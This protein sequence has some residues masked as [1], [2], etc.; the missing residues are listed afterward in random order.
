MCLSVIAI[1][2]RDH[3]SDQ[4]M[5]TVNNTTEINF[6]KLVTHDLSKEK[7]ARITTDSFVD[8]TSSLVIFNPLRSFRKRWD[9]V[10]SFLLAFNLVV[11]PFTI[12]FSVSDGTGTLI[13]WINRVIDALFIGRRYIVIFSS[14]VILTV[15]IPVMYHIVCKTRHVHGL[16]MSLEDLRY[17]L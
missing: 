9:I 15:F 5:T 17:V 12:G 1:T 8:P 10:L 16:I 13:F 2:E 3:C 14:F 4:K 6:K 11:I 7:S